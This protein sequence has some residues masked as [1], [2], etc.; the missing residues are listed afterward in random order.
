MIRQAISCDICAAEKK[1]TNH[2]FV[3]YEQAG[4]LRVSGWSS[5]NRL[6]GNSKHLCGQT[7]LHK[8]MDEFMA[9]TI[10]GKVAVS[11][12]AQ[13]DD[14]EDVMPQA[15]PFTPPPPS[16]HPAPIVRPTRVEL[17]PPVR[18]LERVPPVEH[19]M[20]AAAISK[21]K[22]VPP[23]QDVPSVQ[24]LPSLDRVVAKE[25]SPMNHSSCDDDF[26]SSARIIPTPAAS[27][28]AVA[29]TSQD[30]SLLNHPSYDE[31]FDSYARV[32]P[33]PAKSER[34][35]PAAVTERNGMH[36]D[37]FED[38]YGSSARLIPTP[39]APQR[40]VPLTA[41]V[42]PLQSSAPAEPH[43]VPARPAEQRSFF[44]TR[45][46]RAEAW[47]RERE[48]EMRAGERHSEGIIRRHKTF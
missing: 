12:T 47:E 17:A 8:L 16:E 11:H 33:T 25:T 18:H 7:C 14:F 40:S 22:S 24:S 38:E 23:V 42:V 6:R 1:E 35:T 3:A 46:S 10:A 19:V 27:K 4:E 5:R 13:G 45:R 32:I 44:S 37:S 31:E 30:T 36:D 29:S 39:P 26:E 15:A 9:R 41:A 20:P 48:R 2:W 34:V 43:G 28:R 21:A